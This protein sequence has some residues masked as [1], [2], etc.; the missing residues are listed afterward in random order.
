VDA[1]KAEA[2][3]LAQLVKF[4]RARGFAPGRA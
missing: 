4:A 1:A 3:R 2:R